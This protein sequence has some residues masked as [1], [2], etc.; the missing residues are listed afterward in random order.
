MIVVD[1]G[2]VEH[3]YDRNG[4]SLGGVLLV[5]ALGVPTLLTR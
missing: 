4:H 3:S 5:P 2:G 1:G